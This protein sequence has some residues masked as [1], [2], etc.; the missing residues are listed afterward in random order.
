MRV[1]INRLLN[2]VRKKFHG[3]RHIEVEK[4]PDGLYDIWIVHGRKDAVKPYHVVVN[5]DELYCMFFDVA[6]YL[7][8][9]WWLK[10]MTFKLESGETFTMPVYVME[11]FVLAAHP[12]VNQI[13]DEMTRN[14]EFITLEELMR[15]LWSDDECTSK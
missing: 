15:R 1:I 3:Y 13:I 12:L 4:R 7:D 8:E 14:G 2:F 11:D 5:R 6:L 10:D 9:S